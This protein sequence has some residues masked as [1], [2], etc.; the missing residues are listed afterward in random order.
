MPTAIGVRTLTNEELS[1]LSTSQSETLGAVA[2]AADGRKFTYVGFGG[3]ATI[4]SGQIVVAPALSANS[5]GLAL[6]SSNSAANLSVGSRQLIVTNGSTA[7][8]ANQFA[9]G[10]VEVLWSGGPFV[11][12]ISGNS[13]ASASG[14]ITLSL[15][16]PLTNASALVV[17]TDTVN[18]TASPA[19]SVAPST[20][21]SAPIGV[22]IVS[23]PN[24]AA[25]S[26]YGWVQTSGHTLITGT[27][28]K[29]QAVKQG[30]ATAGYAAVTAA[31]TDYAI[32][33]AK[34]TVT[35]AAAPVEL[36]LA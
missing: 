16:E 2:A 17:G 33:V 5:T 27:T 12:R 28:V 4:P 6:S 1:S 29:G 26:Y 35:G 25:L 22:T 30:T 23:V 31:A 10:F 36:H 9:D 7:V 3:T 18:L 19:A 14:A 24:T 8:T 32:G 20:T 34:E 11:V 15:A 13:A 21:V